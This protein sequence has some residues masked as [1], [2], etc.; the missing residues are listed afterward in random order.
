[1]KLSNYQVLDI[2]CLYGAYFENENGTGFY[3]VGIGVSPADHEIIVELQSADDPGNVV[4]VMWST[5]KDF[6]VQF[7]PHRRPPSS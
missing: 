4:G 3:I 5:L 1:M 7:R 2:S 6:E